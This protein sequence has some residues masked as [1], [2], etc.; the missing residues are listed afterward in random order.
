MD[1]GRLTRTAQLDELQE[2]VRKVQVVFPGEAP[3]K[4]FKL[5]GLIRQ[6]STGP[7]VTAICELESDYAL[8]EIG[9]QPGVRVQS[10]PLSLEEIFLELFE[11]KEWKTHSSENA[12]KEEEIFGGKYETDHE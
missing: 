5:P 7:V 8:N 10:F 3:G 1:R 4:T 6:E 11:N 9:K 12:L 2:R